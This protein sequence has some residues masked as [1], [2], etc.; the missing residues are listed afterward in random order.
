[1]VQC[2]QYYPFHQ[3]KLNKK[4]KELIPDE[5][6]L[7]AT[8]STEELILNSLRFN[9][10]NATGGE[11]KRVSNVLLKNSYLTPEQIAINFNN[12]NVLNE[13]YG[14]LN[15]KS[16]ISID[17]MDNYRTLTSEISDERKGRKRASLLRK[18]SKIIKETNDKYVNNFSSR[19]VEA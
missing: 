16:F 17:D 4:K 13:I 2:F 6:M 5:E 12:F 1:M 14:A 7:T 9:N 19:P 8:A 11:I 18:L 15:R 3:D 10:P